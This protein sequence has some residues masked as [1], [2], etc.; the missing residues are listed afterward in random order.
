MLTMLRMAV[1]CSALAAIV[2]WNQSKLTCRT[3]RRFL[4]STFGNSS[5]SRSIL[6]MCASA[7][8][9]SL[10][11]VRFSGNST[12]QGNVKRTGACIVTT[13]PVSLTASMYPLMNSRLLSTLRLCLVT[14][15]RA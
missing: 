4:A 8:Y 11:W 15:I 1:T 14:V 5:W 9:S 12:R 13:I 2:G 7:S 6:L 3:G 10:Y